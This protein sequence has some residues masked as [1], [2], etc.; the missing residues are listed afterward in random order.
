MRRGSIA[1][2]LVAIFGCD[3]RTSTPSG[4][5][6][7]TTG[8]GSALTHP[9]A[10]SGPPLSAEAPVEASPWRAGDSALI[11]WQGRWWRGRILA[12]RGPDRYFI[13]YDGW[14]ARWDE[15]VPG[16]RLAPIEVEA[17]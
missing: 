16:A 12:V 11:L 14:E 2:V 13:H 4:T 17:R 10:V 5:G 3:A 15:E 8:G 6:S 7:S 1:L 9:G